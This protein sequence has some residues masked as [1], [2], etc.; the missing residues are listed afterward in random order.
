LAEQ[1]ASSMADTFDAAL[2][3]LRRDDF[4]RA[5]SDAEHRL[6]SDPVAWAQYTDERDRWLNAELS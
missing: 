4:Y 6:Q 5:M 3:A 1:R 2:E